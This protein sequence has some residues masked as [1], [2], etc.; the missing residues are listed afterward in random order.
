VPFAFGS[1]PA[2]VWELK[3]RFVSAPMSSL[4]VAGEIFGG[5]AQ[6]VG[7]SPRLVN[8]YGIVGRLTWQSLAFETFLKFNDWGAYDYYKD[9]NLTYPMQVMGD[10]SYAFGIPVWLV[11]PQTR[12]G[13]RGTY[14]TLNGF[15]NRFVPNPS[16]PG[17]LGNE[18]EIRTYLNVSL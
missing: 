5:P 17:A 10:L 16:N 9:F 4:R 12:I 18:W 15:S 1:P 14:R 2:N 6:A 7:P 13:V 3:A 11:L 8:R